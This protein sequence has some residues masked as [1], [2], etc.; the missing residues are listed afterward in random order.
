MLARETTSK[1]RLKKARIS[2]TIAPTM[3]ETRKLVEKKMPGN[4]MTASTL[5]GI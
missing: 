2:A 4:T 3:P 1:L 5:Y